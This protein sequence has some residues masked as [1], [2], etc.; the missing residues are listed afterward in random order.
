VGYAYS[1]PLSVIDLAGAEQSLERVVARNDESGNVDEEF[2]SNVE[3]NEEEVE[4]SEA[5]D[6]VDLGDR[7]LLLKVVECGVLGQ[8]EHN[9]VSTCGFILSFVDSG[10]NAW[11]RRILTIVPCA[12]ARALTSLSSCDSWAWALSWTDM[13][14]A[15]WGLRVLGCK[16]FGC[17][18]MWLMKQRGCNVFSRLRGAGTWRLEI[19]GWR[20]WARHR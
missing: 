19:V 17:N 11:I 9:T 8:L 4:A 1:Q 16:R 10:R 3:E 5:K 2:S 18:G 6:H 20:K 14:R 12:E 15:V 7:R 13:L